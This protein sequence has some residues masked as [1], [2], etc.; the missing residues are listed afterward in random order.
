MLKTWTKHLGP[1]AATAALLAWLLPA[2]TGAETKL[3]DM[4][5]RWRGAGQDR[6]AP[7][8]SLQRTNCQTTIRADSGRM[9]SE[10]VC[11]SSDGHRKVVHLSMTLDGDQLT[12]TVSQR[13]TNRRSNQL[14]SVRNGSLAGQRTD[15]TANLQVS[16]SDLTPRT[17]VALKLNG[18]SS[19]SMKVT[20]LGLTMMDVTFNRGAV[21]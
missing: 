3:S 21:H 1:A 4:N 19:Y 9:S 20:A 15:T 6:N 12:G 10:M 5:G 17:T 8:Q 13:L 14:V 16:W 11:D 18:G 7:W 2:P